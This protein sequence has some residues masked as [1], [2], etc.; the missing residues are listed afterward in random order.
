MNFLFRETYWA[1]ILI[2]AG[3]LLII[4]NVFKVDLPVMGIVIPVIIISLGISLLMGSRESS[5]NENTV[6]FHGGSTQV[7]EGGQHSVVFGKGD[8]D[9][10]NVKPNGATIRVDV[11]AVFSSASVMINPNTPTRIKVSS[12]FASGRMPDGSVVTFGE[13][14][15]FTPSYKE[16]EPFVDLRCD[17]VFGDLK[18]FQDTSTTTL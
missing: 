14:K 11:D 16:G 15:Y 9:L 7:R 8:F 13:R 1:G 5:G 12:V 6:F 3:I 4:R 18:I 17:V 2:L 10:R